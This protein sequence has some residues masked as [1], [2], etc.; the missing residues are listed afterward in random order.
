M[1]AIA[2]FAM[3]VMAPASVSTQDT[4]DEGVRR[5]L[6]RLEQILERND[7]AGYGNLLTDKYPPLTFD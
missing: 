7:H 6:D 2:A 5:L 3:T 4:I 1:A